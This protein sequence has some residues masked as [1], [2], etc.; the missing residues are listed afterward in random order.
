MPGTIS[1]PA[2]SIPKP[3][4][5]TSPASAAQQLH[6]QLV[7]ISPVLLG[8]L[9]GWSSPD[10]SGGC[11]APRWTPARNPRNPAPAPPRR[12]PPTRSPRARERILQP[13][14]ELLRPPSRAHG[15]KQ[16]PESRVER[17]VRVPV[18]VDVHPRRRWASSSIRSTCSCFG[19]VVLVPA[20]SGERPAA[21][22]RR[23]VR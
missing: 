8:A 18:C 22:R 2:S 17:D 13:V 21:G 4:M 3:T 12:R 15:R 1:V 16:L 23:A 14:Q 20:P 5:P 10:T 11:P 6:G 9:A 7:G 19:R